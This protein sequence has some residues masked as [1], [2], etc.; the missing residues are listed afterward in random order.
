MFKSTIHCGDAKKRWSRHRCPLMVL[1]VVAMVLVFCQNGG[2]LVEPKWHI[3]IVQV[4]LGKLIGC[5]SKWKTDV[6]P[7]MWMSS[8]VLTIHNFGVPNFD[9]YPIV[10]NLWFQILRNIHIMWTSEKTY[11]YIYMYRC[12][13]KIGIIKHDISTECSFVHRYCQKE[14]IQHQSKAQLLPRFFMIL[15][16]WLVVWNKHDF[17]FFIQLGM[18]SSQLTNSYFSEG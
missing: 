13:S 7:Q 4:L 16:S 8:L 15:Y 12:F 6:G 18:S 5:G 11:I 10:Y 2:R 9:P 14:K 1:T 3:Q 17:Y